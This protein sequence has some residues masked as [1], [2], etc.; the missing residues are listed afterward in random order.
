VRSRFPW[1]VGLVWRWDA[2]SGVLFPVDR[3]AYPFCLHAGFDCWFLQLVDQSGGA[4]ASLFVWV[5]IMGLCSL[6]VRFA[7]IYARRGI[8]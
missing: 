7:P 6:P 4:P 1:S 3:E 2:D 5:S 8:G